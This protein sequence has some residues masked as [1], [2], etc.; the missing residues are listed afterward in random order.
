MHEYEQLD[1]MLNGWKKT[2]YI[3]LAYDICKWLLGE[4]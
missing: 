1:S 3:R 2:K 4:D